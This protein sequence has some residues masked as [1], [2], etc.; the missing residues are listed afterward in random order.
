[1][2][3]NGEIFR[4]RGSSRLVTPS[5]WYFWSRASSTARACLPYL[6]KTSRLRTFSTR[7]RRVSG[8]WSKATWQMRSKGSRSFPTSSANGSSNRPSLSNY[9]KKTLRTRYASLNAFL[10]QWNSTER[11]QAIIEELESEGLLLEPLADEV[12]KDLDPFDLICH[13]AFDQPPLTRRER[14]ENVRKRDVF[15]KYG[16]QARTVLEALLQKYQ[17]EGVTSLDDPQ[18][19]KISPF[20]TMG[21]PIELLKTFGG[22][23][24]FEKAVHELQSALYQGAA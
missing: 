20:D 4:M 13:V 6:V 15:T 11:K 8:G 14:V 9:S 3:S 24:G 22:R 12:G 7:S 5:S 1:M 10:K 21:T 2:V 16:K 19:L 18:I 17:D 23:P